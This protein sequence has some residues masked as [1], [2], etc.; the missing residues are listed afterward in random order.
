LCFVRKVSPGI[1]G[2]GGGGRQ[3]QRT[4]KTGARASGL[5]A[6]KRRESKKRGPSFRPVFCARGEGAQL[7]SRTGGPA[8]PRRRRRGAPAGALIKKSNQAAGNG[9]AAGAHR[10]K[11]FGVTAATTSGNGFPWRKTEAGAIVVGAWPARRRQ[12]NPGV[13]GDSGRPHFSRKTPSGTAW[14]GA[15]SGEKQGKTPR[16]RNSLK[17]QAGG[18]RAGRASITDERTF[19]EKKKTFSGSEKTPGGVKSTLLRGGRVL[20]ASQRAPRAPRTRAAAVPPRAERP[21]SFSA[22][23]P[24]SLNRCDCFINRFGRRLEEPKRPGRKLPA[25]TQLRWPA[26]QCGPLPRQPR[27]KMNVRCAHPEALAGGG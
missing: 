13:G 3:R 6:R 24:G 10:N 7:D 18:V 12:N 8:P 26:F 14:G 15:P 17:P 16:R 20:V 9:S 22:V 21:A 5:L 23:A 27:K 4:R 11:G 19:S 2:G 25:K 1:L